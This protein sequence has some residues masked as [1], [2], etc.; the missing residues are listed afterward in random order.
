MNMLRIYYSRTIFVLVAASV[1]VYSARLLR[2]AGSTAGAMGTPSSAL[3]A[4]GLS[5]ARGG[6][7]LLFFSDRG[8]RP[9]ASRAVLAAAALAASPDTQWQHSLSM[10]EALV[11]LWDLAKAQGRLIFEPDA[12]ST[13]SVWHHPRAITPGRDEGQQVGPAAA[14][15]FDLVYNPSRA[16]KRLP[17]GESPTVVDSVNRGWGIGLAAEGIEAS[18]QQGNGGGAGEF[19]FHH[20][21]EH[22]IL[23]GFQY[24]SP[25][26][27]DLRPQLYTWWIPSDGGDN[28]HANGG[29]SASIRLDSHRDDG[30]RGHVSTSSQRSKEA[31]VE[32]GYFACTTSRWKNRMSSKSSYINV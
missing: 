31:T 28:A 18:N 26:S 23:F 5:C 11:D 8:H 3:A 19:N 27:H 6:K 9:R 4:T 21:D 1:L 30:V 10:Q 16:K 15:R 20:I 32:G 2:P 17:K 12:V 24:S 29:V 7:E 25:L 14:Q 22:E 13:R